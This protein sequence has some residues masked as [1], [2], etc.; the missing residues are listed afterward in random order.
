MKYKK[1][2]IFFCSIVMILLVLLLSFIIIYVKNTYFKNDYNETFR[3]KHKKRSK[4]SKRKN[5]RFKNGKIKGGNYIKRKPNDKDVSIELYYAP[6]CPY[7]KEIYSVDGKKKKMWNK[8][9]RYLEK[10]E[11]ND[12]YV[13]VM[14]IDCTKY[15]KRC[16]SVDS[17][18]T[19]KFR[20]NGIEKVYKGERTF[21]DVISFLNVE[22]F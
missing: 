17:Y 7:C 19:I 16:K 12:M 15:K 14:S 21:D 4:K 20:K 11:I 22:C 2:N 10:N 3:S 5:E 8:L 18:P 1:D 13:N 9:E 6:W